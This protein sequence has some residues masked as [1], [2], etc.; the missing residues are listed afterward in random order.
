MA[1]PLFRS[2]DDQFQTPV[3][4]RR[5]TFDLVLYALWLRRERERIEGLTQFRRFHR[6][7]LARPMARDNFADHLRSFSLS[8]RR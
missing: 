1:V 2:E 4:F 7:V 3:V 6:R 5:S 8:R